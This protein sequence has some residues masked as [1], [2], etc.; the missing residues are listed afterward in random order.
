MAI[1]SD[2]FLAMRQTC[3]VNILLFSWCSFCHE[4]WE[5]RTYFD[6]LAHKITIYMN[7]AT[8]SLVSH[9]TPTP[10]LIYIIYGGSLKPSNSK[11]LEVVVVF[12][13]SFTLKLQ[14]YDTTKSASVEN[15]LEITKSTQQRGW[16]E[17][18]NLKEKSMFRN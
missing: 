4:V 3:V 7:G 1:C 15:S 13:F 12:S 9:N 17:N 6:I 11:P 10:A 8:F 18:S 14:F 16:L 5:R 2:C